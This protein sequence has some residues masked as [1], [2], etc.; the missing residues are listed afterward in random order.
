MPEENEKNARNWKQIIATALAAA[1]AALVPSVIGWIKVQAS[2][3][4]TE[5]AFDDY[6]EFIFDR[7][8]RDEA[9]ERALLDCLIERHGDP[10]TLEEVAAEHGYDP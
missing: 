1:I 3:Q 9:L 10:P 6:R 5:R 8:E 4:Q 2:E 7:A